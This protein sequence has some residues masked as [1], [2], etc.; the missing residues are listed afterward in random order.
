MPPVD[1]MRG[2]EDLYALLE[3]VYTEFPPR[4][5]KR[6]LNRYWNLYRYFLRGVEPVIAEHPAPAQ[7]LD[8]GAGGGVIPLVLAK[9]GYTVTALDTWELYAKE[10]D[11][12]MGCLEEF[13]E[14]FSR[15]GI[16]WERAILG[17]DRLPFPDETFE[18]VS[19]FDVIEHLPSPS[20]LL[21]EAHRLLKPGGILVVSTPNTANLRNRIRH[22]FGASP[23]PDAIGTWYERP[24]SG[25]VR[26]YTSGELE[27]MFG[28][29]GFQTLTVNLTESSHQ[30]T[31]LPNGEWDRGLR[32]TSLE[33]WIKAGYFGCVSM[34]PNLRYVM[35]AIGRKK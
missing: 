21:V 9:L 25:H 35:L 15:F 6:A 17:S 28:R 29:A 31:K 22:L 5:Q 2:R 13:V 32:L 12:P 20:D 23:H 27:E 3:E 18:F 4:A 11:N 30:N 10:R 33:Q 8:I 16:A 19:A 26:E 14:R 24:F 7:W 34:F 1:G